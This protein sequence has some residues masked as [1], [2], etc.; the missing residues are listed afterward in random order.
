M[1]NRTVFRGLLIASAFVATTANAQTLR[2]VVA[3]TENEQFAKASSM[4]RTLLTTDATSGEV[5]FQYGENFFQW[6]KQDSANYCYKKGVEVN[7]RYP[8]GHVGLG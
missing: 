1:N 7:P 2:Q 6:D 5:W 3:L 4:F 8:L